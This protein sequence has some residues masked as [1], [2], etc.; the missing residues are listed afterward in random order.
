MRKTFSQSWEGTGEHL[1]FTKRLEMS[2]RCDMAHVC[3]LCPES[4]HTG[5][6]SQCLRLE[7]VRNTARER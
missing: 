2:A 3:P 6:L 5:C 7:E 1:V 4:P